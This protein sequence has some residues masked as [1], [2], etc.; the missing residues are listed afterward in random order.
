VNG[1][2]QTVFTWLAPEP[3][4][5]FTGDIQPL[6]EGLTA[7]NGPKASDYIGYIAFGSETFYQPNQNATLYVPKLEIKL[8]K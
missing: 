4:T 6:L 8:E 7:F 2:Q 1:N 3:A 5:K